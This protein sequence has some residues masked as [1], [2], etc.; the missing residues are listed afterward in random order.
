M[1]NVIM[2]SLLLS[3]ARALSTT[4]KAS[5]SVAAAARALST[6]ST[7][8]VILQGGKTHLFKKQGSPIVY[9][10]AIGK[11]EGEPEAGGVVDVVDGGGGLIGWGLFNPHSMYRVRLLATTERELLA[12]RDVGSV[13]RHRLAAAAQLRRACGLPSSETT[14]YRLVNSEGDRLSGLTVDVFGGTAVAVTSALWLEQ[15][16]E[17]VMAALR[18]L[19]DVDEVVW[20]RSDGRLQQDGWQSEKRAEDSEKRDHDAGS[21]QV[22]IRESGLKFLVAPA[23]GQKSGYYCDQ[24]DNRRLL[25]EVCKDRTVLDLFCYSG[26]FSIAAA[27]AGASKCVG[28]DSSAY[29]LDL[30][31]Q[32]AALNGLECEFLQA[33]VH[34]FLKASKDG[35]AGQQQQQHKASSSA[36]KGD[37]GGLQEQYDVVVCDPPK[38]APSVKDLSRATR[39]YRELNGGAMRATKPGGLLLS[40]SC[41]AAMTQSGGF[42]R[43]LHEAAQAEGRTLTILRTSGAAPDHVIHP[44]APEGAY[45][46]A[47]LAHVA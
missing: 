31:K 36:G 28:V 25:A 42:V 46:T 45:L 35:H 32:N 9:G 15:R 26:G 5:I 18:E 17:E 13:V 38:L 20:R 2:F 23:L 19:P 12:H 11:V 47:V 10:G 30:A 44:G 16:R 8:R 27:A 3:S 1:A 22:E 33:D 39:K 37:G 43:M 40:C 41:S 4:A 14:A 21:E 29:A 7:A 34:R 6:T 24:R